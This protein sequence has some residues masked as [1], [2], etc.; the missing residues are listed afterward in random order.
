[1][2][3]KGDIRK[4]FE[5]VLAGHCA[6]TLLSQ[7]CASLVSLSRQCFPDLSFLASYQSFLRS[8]GISCRLL[9]RCE[10]R[11]L[12]FLYREDQ[13]CRQLS[14]KSSR[15]LLSSWGYPE[16]VDPAALLSY[17]EGRFSES[18]S[19]PHEIGLFLGYPPADVE[20]FILHGGTNCRLCGYWKVYS[21]VESARRVFA[22][23]DR[24]RTYLIS[25]LKEGTPLRELLPAA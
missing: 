14:L 24:C 9:C 13:L 5:Y 25:R 15:R 18:C 1:M 17:L 21:D 20:A 7:K 8:C 23:Y 4:D 22:R 12:L 2:Y 16:T 3:P 6:P 10:K 11:V 19:F